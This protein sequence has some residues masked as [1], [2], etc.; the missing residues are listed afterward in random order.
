M[1]PVRQTVFGNHKGNCFAACVASILELRLDEVPNF[2]CQKPWEA[3]MN[4]WLHE[5]GLHSL[6]C[7]FVPVEGESEVVI[8]ELRGYYIVSGTSPRATEDEHFLH[9]V[10]YL[11]G[12]RC[13]DPHPDQTWTL[14]VR[15]WTFF[16]PLDA[17]QAM[18]GFLGEQSFGEALARAE[19]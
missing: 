1:K 5:R 7:H 19:G 11:D 10:V 4:A 8:P 16:L 12:E 13:H 6:T 18:H 2:A 9:S 15:D 3:K 17:R 14:D